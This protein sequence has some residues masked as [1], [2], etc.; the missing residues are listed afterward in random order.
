MTE[1]IKLFSLQNNLNGYKH[2]T[3]FYFEGL[4]SHLWMKF[5]DTYKGNI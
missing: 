5:Q 4:G 3:D 1:L 2:I